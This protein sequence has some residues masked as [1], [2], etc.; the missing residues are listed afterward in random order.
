[1]SNTSQ[2]P[3]GRSLLID[4]F[5]A[6]GCLLIV[7]HHMAFYG[8]MSDVVAVAWPAVVNWLYD[9]GRLALQFFLVCAGFLTA[10]SLARY[11]SLDLSEAL[12]LVWQRSLRLAIP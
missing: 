3:S 10:G 4:A 6:A 1:L 9:D 5:K 7:L 12:K 2:R 8:P 11:A